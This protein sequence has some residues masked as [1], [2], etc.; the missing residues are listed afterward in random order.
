M[1]GTIDVRRVEFD[2]ERFA[3]GTY[4]TRLTSMVFGFPQ[5]QVR[6]KL[7]YHAAKAGGVLSEID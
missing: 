7:K 1:F 5:H 4:S 3:L 6:M 2:I